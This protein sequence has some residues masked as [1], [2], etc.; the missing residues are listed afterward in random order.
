MDKEF[1]LDTLYRCAWTGAQ[2]LL[3]FI[4]VGTSIIEIP[5]R[6]ALAITATAVA[7]CFIKQVGLYCH[8]KIK[9]EYDDE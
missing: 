6:A 8:R 3:G 2:C 9:E 4:T 1:W 7:A 5:W